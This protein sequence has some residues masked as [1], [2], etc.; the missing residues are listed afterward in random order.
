MGMALISFVCFGA[1]AAHGQ[2]A[3]AGATSSTTI[4]RGRELF[5]SRC[6]SCHSLD[7][8]RTGPML[9]GVVGRRVGEA[10]GYRY[11]PALA[12]AEFDWDEAR[13]DLWLSGPSR[14]ILGVRMRASVRE[15]G[16]RRAI[17][18]YLRSAR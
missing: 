8:N 7:T 11:S 16:D 6:A 10:A 9:R 17:I 12:A 5:Q 14:F 2:S 1:P 13:L 3:A 15:A 18:A 4:E